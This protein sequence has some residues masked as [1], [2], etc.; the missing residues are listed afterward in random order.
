MNIDFDNKDSR[1][2]RFPR[3]CHGFRPV[4]ASP[5]WVW[6]LAGAACAMI[7]LALVIS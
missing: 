6:W 2:Y 1:Q 3:E 7:I 4:P 5:G